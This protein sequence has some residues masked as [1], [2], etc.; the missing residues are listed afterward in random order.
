MQQIIKVFLLT[1]TWLTII[2]YTCTGPLRHPVRRRRHDLCR[3][4]EQP[5]CSYKIFNHELTSDAQQH[6]LQLSFLITATEMP[7]N[8]KNYLPTPVDTRIMS[9][10]NYSKL[11]TE[12]RFTDNY[13]RTVKYQSIEHHKFIAV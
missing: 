13:R 7:S 6:R 11:A 9:V 8:S 2:N 1:A 3:H 4:V 12:Q 10:S 5:A